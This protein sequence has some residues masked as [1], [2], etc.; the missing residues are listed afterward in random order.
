MTV[1]QRL[2]TGDWQASGPEMRRWNVMGDMSQ[3]GRWMDKNAN[4]EFKK[5]FN[6]IHKKKDRFPASVKKYNEKNNK[7]SKQS[8]ASNKTAIENKVQES[9]TEVQNQSQYA[10][11]ITEFGDKFINPYNFIGL[12]DGAAKKKQDMGINEEELLTG[13]VTCTMRTKTPIFIPNTSNDDAFEYKSSFPEHKSYDFFSYENLS[14]K[15]KMLN[16]PA[17]P[18]IP[19]SSIRGVIRSAYEALTDSCMMTSDKPVTGRNTNIKKPGILK[20][21]VSGKWELYESVRYKLKTYSDGNY[22]IKTDKAGQKY[23]EINGKKYATGDEIVFNARK[24]NKGVGNLAFD[25]GNEN[26]KMKGILILGEPFGDKMEKKYDSIFELC[27]A[28]ATSKI[29]SDVTLAVKQLKEVL[30]VYNDPAVNKNL[31][32]DKKP[33]GWHNGYQQYSLE[34]K[35]IYPVWYDDRIPDKIYLAPACISRIAYY[36]TIPDILKNNGGYNAC[37]STDELCPACQLFGMIGENSAAGSKIRFSD[38]ELAGAFN[39]NNCYDE[40]ITLEELSSPKPSAVEFYTKR[41]EVTKPGSKPETVPAWNYDYTGPTRGGIE[42]LGRKAYW[43]SKKYKAA[44]DKTNRNTTV[45]PVKTGVEFNFKIYYERI[46]REELKKLIWVITIGENTLE[47]VQCH[48]IGGAKP[49]GLG[50]AKIKAEKVQNRRLAIQNGTITRTCEEEDLD[51]L[52]EEAE[53]KNNAC[54]EFM[55]ISNLD[56]MDEQI[57]QYPFGKETD[58][59][60]NIKDKNDTGGHVWFKNNRLAGKNATGTNPNIQFTLKGILDSPALPQLKK[61]KKDRSNKK[62]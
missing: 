50:S 40:I 43:H 41:P 42:I 4:P 11:R 21:S 35:E 5:E 48:K 62:H 6:D 12:G 37:V 27:K 33:E 14:G 18:V 44:E 25:I 51:K 10:N 29:S 53:F 9:A 61:P 20:K 54:E 30:A 13:V 28:N 52:L 2:L 15:K 47:G 59:A 7:N 55:K 46:T 49:L 8:I 56:S 60:G 39:K 58:E 24:A 26:G 17:N 19:G 1:Q 34:G 3:L 38:A 31:K 45:R 32:T 23:I 16:S 57:V 22:E 36:N